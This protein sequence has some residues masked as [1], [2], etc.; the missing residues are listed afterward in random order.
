MYPPKVI[1]SGIVGKHSNKVDMSQIQTLLNNLKM[2]NAS[3]SASNSSSHIGIKLSHQNSQSSANSAPMA[4]GVP[5]LVGQANG[6][7]YARSSSRGKDSQANKLSAMLGRPT[8]F[9][10]PV[11]T[12]NHPQMHSGKFS[13]E[14]IAQMYKAQ[15]PNFHP[16]PSAIRMKLGSDPRD[17]PV[18]TVIQASQRASVLSNNLV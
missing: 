1:S 18:A 3:A 2:S 8:A 13:G 5:Q 14:N 15:A 7:T 9:N 11:S 4:M 10:Q 6:H 12:R 16:R 17:L